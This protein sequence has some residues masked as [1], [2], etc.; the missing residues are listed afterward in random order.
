MGQEVTYD[1][2]RASQLKKLADAFSIQ[3]KF[4]AA[5]NKLSLDTKRQAAAIANPDTFLRRARL[6]LPDGLG[7]ELFREP[8]RFFPFPD[9]TPW[10]IELT[11]CRRYWVIECDDVPSPSGL[12]KCELQH[13]EVC[14]GFRIYPQ[15]WPRGPY[16]L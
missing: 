11:S 8:P 14:L 6:S 10:V 5:L 16:S 13:G 3:P 12:R 1:N 4:L 15:P 9:W 2:K 7:F